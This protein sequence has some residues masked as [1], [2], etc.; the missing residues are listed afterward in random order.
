M[1]GALG[2]PFTGG[3]GSQE[4][5]RTLSWR[6]PTRTLRLSGK[7]KTLVA[8]THLS[9][10]PGFLCLFIFYSFSVRTRLTHARNITPPHDS[11]LLKP[12]N[13]S[14][15]SIEASGLDREH[16]LMFSPP[17]ACDTAFPWTL[18]PLPSGLLPLW[19]DIRITRQLVKY[20]LLVPPYPP[21]PQRF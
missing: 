18:F 9:V 20:R 21:P 3:R 16:R 12:S 15:P 17:A 1:T 6:I 13:G 2:T 4:T 14:E 5:T 19:K 7:Q 8:K 11:T 10:E